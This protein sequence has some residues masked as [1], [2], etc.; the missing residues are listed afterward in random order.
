MDCRDKH[1]LADLARCRNLTLGSKA[2][3]T[4]VINEFWLI[5]AHTIN[6]QVLDFSSG[7]SH[8]Y[9]RASL[10][11]IFALFKCLFFGN[12]TSFEKI[13]EVTLVLAKHELS[14]GDFAHFL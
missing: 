9:H 8:F 11:G 14:S 10:V 6:R 13:L 1:D 5:M 12:Q 4:F 7:K 3:W 2:V